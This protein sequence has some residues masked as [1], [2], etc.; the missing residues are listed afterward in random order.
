[1]IEE[2][3]DIKP[4]VNLPMNLL[5]DF[6]WLWI[7][8]AVIAIGLGLY[9]F[10]RHRK[11]VKLQQVVPPLPPWEMAL[12]QL[13]ELGVKDFPGRG[14]WREYYFRLSDI[15]RHYIE[16]RFVIKAAEMTTEEF[17]QKVKNEG[18]LSSEQKST[19][20]DFM[21][22]ADMVKF[23]KLAPLREEADKSYDLVLRFV[24]ETIPHGI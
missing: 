24:K 13:E 16:D 8:L 5:E 21:N 18:V 10:L 15:L 19:L 22:I 17:L 14:E 11:K 4:P 12:R 7:L 9:F 2:I 20:K 23:A 3:K 6:W 1:M